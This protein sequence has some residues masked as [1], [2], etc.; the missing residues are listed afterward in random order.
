[1]KYFSFAAHRVSVRVGSVNIYAGGKIV[2]VSQVAVHENYGNF[3]NDLAVVTL[4]EKLVK[5]DKID[6]INVATA[7][8]AENTQITIAGWG[9]TEIGGA[10][11]YRLQKGDGKTISHTD[12]EE[13][14]G[15][16]YEHVLCVASPVGKGMCNGDAGAPAVSKNTLVAIGSFSIGTCATEFP[17]VYTSLAAYKDWLAQK[18]L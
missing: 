17:D 7:E 8:P 2:N 6:F 5:S 1:M 9:S 18:A 13:S 3:I 15:F 4:A 10:N 12:C 14:I 11:S 16:G